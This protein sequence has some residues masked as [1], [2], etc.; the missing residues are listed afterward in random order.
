MLCA[1]LLCET[2]FRCSDVLIFSLSHIYWTDAGTNRIEVATLDGRYRKWL[3][4]RDLDQ[5]AAIVVNPA[6]G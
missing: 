1:W 5:P 3:I 4:Y 6:L 2:S